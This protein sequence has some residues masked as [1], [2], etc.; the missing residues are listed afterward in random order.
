MNEWMNMW[1]FKYPWYTSYLVFTHGTKERNFNQLIN[2]NG[3]YDDHRI[4]LP[5]SRFL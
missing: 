5:I 2:N 3:E 1:A 4:S